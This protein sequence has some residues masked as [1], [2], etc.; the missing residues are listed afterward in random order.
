MHLFYLYT[1]VCVLCLPGCSQTSKEEGIG[2][3]GIE[4]LMVTSH[5]A[6]ARNPD[7]LQE[8]GF[9]APLPFLEII[10]HYVVQADLRLALLLLLPS[11]PPLSP[12]LPHPHLSA[13]TS[14]LY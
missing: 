1:G 13:P 12:P 6:G 5:C 11:T 7:P 10:S 14:A 9:L 2:S 4:F 8:Q 3:C